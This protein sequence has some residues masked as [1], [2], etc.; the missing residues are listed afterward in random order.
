MRWVDTD[1]LEAHEEFIGLYQA[2]STNAST[3]LSIIRDVLL[4][5]NITITRLRGQCYNGAASMSG[6]KS[7]VATEGMR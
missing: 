3:I 7:S 6:Y 2:D 4:R 5:L 1:N